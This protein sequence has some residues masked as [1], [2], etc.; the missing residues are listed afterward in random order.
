[1]RSSDEP[2]GEASI[3]RYLTADCSAEEGAAIEARLSSDPAF[4]K[5][6]ELVR[7]V[8][9][10]TESASTSRPVERAWADL[11]ARLHEQSHKAP[12]SESRARFAPGLS[13][14][15]RISR[16]AA[17]AAAV[18]VVAGAG[19][20]ARHADRTRSSAAAVSPAIREYATARGE[21]AD[22]RLSDG[23]RVML[24][25]A[26]VLRVPA[27]FT[28]GSREV[29]LDGTAY[30]DVAHD[31]LRPFRVRT[32]HGVAEDLG[33]SFVV[34]A[35]PETRG[36]RVA[37][38][39]GIVALSRSLASHDRLLLKPGDLGRVDTG[40]AVRGESGDVAAALARTK[41]QLVFRAKPLADAVLELER[42]YDIEI[43]LVTPA[44][45]RV[46]LSATIRDEGPLETIR[47][48][49]AAAG[50][51]LLPPTSGQ[52]AYLLTTP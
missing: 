26:S 51:R 33:T 45:G 31:S 10:L 9:Q 27:A 44:L 39:S 41:G 40:G 7:Q 19:L 17:L 25:A 28:N 52:P 48:I 35:Y 32:A 6:V 38:E 12:T 24:G 23:T 47:F 15:G 49:A 16:V 37:V 22:L 5:E 43:R 2:P 14:P 21:R 30:F 20:V 4:A 36:M 8:W 3:L 34:T 42:W 50:A 11:R 18:I 29:T 13:Q 1:M 46:P